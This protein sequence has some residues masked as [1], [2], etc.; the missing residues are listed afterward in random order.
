MKLNSDIVENDHSGRHLQTVNHGDDQPIIPLVLS[1]SMKRKT[2]SANIWASQEHP[3][4][5]ETFLPLLHV[6]SFS[7]KQ[8][9]KL[10]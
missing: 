6:L 5:I 9:R 4:S 1:K 2:V 8:I 3:L 7:S 10:S